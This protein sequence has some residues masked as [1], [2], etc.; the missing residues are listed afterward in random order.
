MSKRHDI[1][2]FD[3]RLKSPKAEIAQDGIILTEVPMMALKQKKEKQEAYC[4]SKLNILAIWER[5]ILAM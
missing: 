3:K 4:E 2:V 5:S 1:Q